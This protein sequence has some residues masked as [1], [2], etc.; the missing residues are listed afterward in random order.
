MR[1]RRVAWPGG[2]TR[3]WNHHRS[4][5]ENLG[6]ARK[7]SCEVHPRLRDAYGPKWSTL[8]NLEKR[9]LRR[10]IIS[11]S[12]KRTILKGI[13]PCA[14][15]KIWSMYR[16]QGIDFRRMERFLFGAFALNN[17]AFDLGDLLG[18]RNLFRTDLCAFP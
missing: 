7:I 9:C 13:N 15:R 3:E 10:R 18:D 2:Q 5:N 12:A 11:Q 8:R 17:T 6:W 4:R 16:F 14:H 1:R